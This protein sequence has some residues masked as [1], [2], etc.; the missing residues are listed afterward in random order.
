MTLVP[1]DP[2]PD[3]DLPRDGGG[4]V[5]LSQLAGRPVVLFIYPADDTP[6]CTTEAQDFTRLLP[7]FEALG[8]TVL[9]L[10]A[11]D[12]AAKDR[13]RD[14]A[15][16]G[17]PLLADETGDTIRAYG[18]WGEKSMYGRRYEGILRTTVLIGADGRVLRVWNVSRVKN[19]AAQVLDAVRAAAAPA[20]N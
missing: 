6:G 13:F 16:L 15:G 20:G 1:G 12:A 18:A 10:S 17:V 19:H 11:G 9:G 14:K 5:S 8:A 3:F 7:E 2:A 4:R